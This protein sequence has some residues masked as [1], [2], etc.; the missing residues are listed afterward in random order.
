MW[1]I[2]RRDGLTGSGACHTIYLETRLSDYTTSTCV[3]FAPRVI[4]ATHGAGTVE[5][6]TMID[7]I[8]EHY[9]RILGTPLDRYTVRYSRDAGQHLAIYVYA[10]Q[11]CA[12]AVALITAGLSLAPLHGF[13]EEL[14]FLCYNNYYTAELIKLLGW[15]AT[16]VAES[17]HPL[18]QGQVVPPAGPLLSSTEME[19][20]YT[21]APVYLPA[22]LWP[23][24]FGQREIPIMWLIPIYTSEAKWITSHG[25]DDFE[26]LLVEQ[27]PDL[28]NLTRP[29]VV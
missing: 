22:A 15:V 19:A 27:D 23:I 3:L 9:D 26:S 20:L 6:M 24:R 21:A 1:I 25:P 5:E 4:G 18:Y 11:P 2:I 28:L 16:E 7:G 29:S 17:Q 12:G 13:N 14:V 10:D 8:R